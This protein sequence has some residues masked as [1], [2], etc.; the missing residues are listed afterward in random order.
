MVSLERT[1][2]TTWSDFSWYE[3]LLQQHRD[4]MMSNN[5]SS[6]LGLVNLVLREHILHQ[7]TGAVSEILDPFSEL[8]DLRSKVDLV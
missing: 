7:V 4:E 3:A 1:A 2:L 8:R 5:Q 6:D